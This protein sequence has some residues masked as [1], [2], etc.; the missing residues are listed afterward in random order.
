MQYART[1]GLVSAVLIN[2]NIIIG[3]G[4]FI[5]LAPIIHAAGAAG[6]LAYVAGAVCLFPVVFVLAA[7][8]RKHPESGGLYVY[9]K[10]Y[11][12]PFV[13]FL[14]G[15]GYF[16]GKSI[17]VGLNAYLIMELLKHI[18][19]GLHLLP[20]IVLVAG[21]VGSFVI[22]NLIGVELQGRAQYL[23]VFAKALPISLAFLLFA[24]HGAVDSVQL[25]HLT[26][27]TMGALLPIAVFA[28]VGFEVTCTIGHLFQNPERNITRVLLYGF[29]V[30]AAILALFQLAVGALVPAGQS[31]VHP[32]A[33]MA[34]T[35]LP[36]MSAI[37]PLLYACIYTSMLGGSFSI[38]TS[39]C[40]NLH[41]LA[42]QG[43][44]PFRS[45][46]I[47]TTKRQVPWVS[48]IVGASISVAGVA[49]TQNQ[50]ALQSM[51]IFGMIFAFCCTMVAAMR[52]R[53]QHGNYLVPLVIKGAAFVSTCYLMYLCLVKIA[54]VGVSMP[55]L[56]LVG[57]GV[58]C[59]A[60][61]VIKHRLCT[62]KKI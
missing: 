49:I 54:H 59:A 41:R 31:L 40:W 2:V 53:D 43:H 46:L 32:V 11:L 17:S 16:V 45:W 24:R 62:M 42:E 48:L 10:T 19:P 50:G 37:V 30:V 6:F 47:K 5:N 7:L 13:A 55:Y 44:L 61:R 9:T 20:N 21:L 39:N 33:T 51:A 52:A 58:L 36:H 27:D 26:V 18:V 8:A 12:H 60:G 29:G 1:I 38:L 3:G 28:M 23:F 35:Y 14:A 56:A 4:A 22:A 15:W 34:S 57:L 25:S